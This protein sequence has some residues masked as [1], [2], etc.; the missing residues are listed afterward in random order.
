MKT[1]TRRAAMLVATGVLGLGGLAVAAP[2][3]AGA[4]P[5][6]QPTVA[7]S[8]PGPAWH[9]GTGVGAGGAGAGMGTTAR[10]GSCADPAPTAAQGALSEQQKTTLATMA[11]EEKVAQ[12]LYRV[13]AGRYQ[14]VVFDR[15]AA[16]EVRHLTA[17]RTLLDRYGLPDPTAGNPAGQFSDPAV[18]A[19]YDSLLAQGQ[20]NQ[21]AALQV[22]Q[23]V[24]QAAITDLQAALNGLTAPDVHQ[25]YNQLLTASQQHLTALRNWSAR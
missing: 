24:E 20:A 15:I 17:I 8:G 12:D 9:A 14:V 5:F 10:D 4:G 19:R 25:V 7:G 2:A 21:A 1:M 11:Q 3:I 13:F 22:G 23:S 16:A 18:Q 6:G